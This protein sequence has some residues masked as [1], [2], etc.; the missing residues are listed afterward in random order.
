MAGATVGTGAGQW[1]LSDGATLDYA[2]SGYFLC[3]FRLGATKYEIEEFT[4]NGV[5]GLGTKNHGAREAIWT[6]QV[7][8]IQSTEQKAASGAFGYINDLLSS[9]VISFTVAGQ[10]GT[11]RIVGEQCQVDQPRNTGRGTYR[12]EVSLVLRRLR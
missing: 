4:A 9:G 11:G 5:T 6:L 1:T 2:N 10:T 12:C 7:F 3:S 8:A